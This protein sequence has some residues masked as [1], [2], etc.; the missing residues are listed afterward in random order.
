MLILVPNKLE[1]EP[2]HGNPRNG[3]EIVYRRLS[4]VSGP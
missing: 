4:S 2:T 1:E 3:F